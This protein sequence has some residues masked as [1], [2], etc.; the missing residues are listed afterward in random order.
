MRKSDYP[1]ASKSPGPVAIATFATIVK[2]GTVYDTAV[3]NNGRQNGL[4]SRKL[5]SELYKI[6]V[7]KVTFVI[8]GYRLNRPP[9]IHTWM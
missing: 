6:M 1:R 2:S 4:I 9:W 8:G 3:K 7:N 5:F